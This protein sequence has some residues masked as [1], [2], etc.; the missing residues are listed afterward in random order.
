[1]EEEQEKCGCGS[2]ETERQYDRYNIYCG[3]MCDKCFGKKYNRDVF[4]AGFCG[5]SL[6]GE[7]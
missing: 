5:E 3:K 4:D 1:M 6:E 7:Y 2:T